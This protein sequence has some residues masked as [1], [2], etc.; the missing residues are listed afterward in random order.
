MINRP[1]VTLLLFILSAVLFS[2]QAGCGGGQSN[3]SHV[4]TSENTNSNGGG[5]TDLTKYP[6]ISSALAGAEFEQMDGTKFT[7]NEKK[8]KVIF[9]TLWGTWCGPCIAEMP[10]LIALQDQYRDRGLEIVGLNVGDGS[11]VPEPTDLINRFAAEKKLNYTI[12]RSVAATREVYK[13]TQADVVPQ[14]LLIDREGRVRG[15]FI[16]GGPRITASMEQTIAKVIA[17]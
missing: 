12:A 9:V 3:V 4:N 17:E 11:G 10:V 2:S 16:G 5:T 7:L 1:L 15:A 13:F 6:P 14:G 8:G